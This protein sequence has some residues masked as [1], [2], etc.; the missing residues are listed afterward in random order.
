MRH[1]LLF[2][3]LDFHKSIMGYDFP[4][5]NGCVQISNHFSTKH[6]STISD[7]LFSLADTY[8]PLCQITE[9]KIKK[10]LFFSAKK[11]L[12][13]P[14]SPKPTRSCLFFLFFS[15]LLF[16]S[17]SLSQSST[18]HIFLFQKKFSPFFQVFV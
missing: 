4:V 3:T 16:S 9:A 5:P 15:F 7:E 11:S 13:H 2:Q 18:S 1:P 6:S 14:M 12:F 10:N 8:A 17:V